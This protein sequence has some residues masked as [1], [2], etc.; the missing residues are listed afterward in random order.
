MR[1]VKFNGDDDGMFDSYRE[2]MRKINNI[3]GSAALDSSTTS[4]DT[5]YPLENV[6]LVFH[7]MEDEDSQDIFYPGA[8]ITDRVQSTQHDH[9]ENPDPDWAFLDRPARHQTFG[10]VSIPQYISSKSACLEI[11]DR[12]IFALQAHT[13]KYFQNAMQVGNVSTHEIVLIANQIRENSRREHRRWEYGHSRTPSLLKRYLEEISDI[14]FDNIR[15]LFRTRSIRINAG[16][17]SYELIG[18]KNQTTIELPLE[19]TPWEVNDD[20]EL[21]S[22]DK[23]ATMP[24]SIEQTPH[25]ES[26]ATRFVQDQY[27]KLID[28]NY[29]IITE[30]DKTWFE[31]QA[32]AIMKVGMVVVQRS[33]IM[34][35]RMTN[36]KLDKI[37]DDI[38]IVM[39]RQLRRIVTSAGVNP[40]EFH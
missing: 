6:R 11:I 10:T 21:M 40:N 39:T 33:F 28:D 37:L 30:M 9:L 18:S 35:G 20:H 14:Y 17:G 24:N 1:H 27:V 4:T 16:D 26:I 29:A 15:E 25:L 7:G 8:S 36:Q 3:F 13:L 34:P 31:Q 32:P 5:P 38:I 12:Q 2:N 22:I 19:H 23:D